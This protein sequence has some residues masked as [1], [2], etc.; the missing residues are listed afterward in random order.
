MS[1]VF[2][3]E[4]IQFM[5]DNAEARQYTELTD[6]LNQAFGK[7]YGMRQVK[8]A[9]NRMGVYNGICSLFSR[10]HMKGFTAG[11]KPSNLCHIGTE[12]P[13]PSGYLKVKISDN[14]HSWQYKHIVLWER[15]HGSVPQGHKVIFADG[16]NRNFAPDNLILVSNAE[17]MVM[18][19]KGLIYDDADLTKVGQKIAKVVVKIHEK[20][21]HK[22]TDEID[23]CG[24]NAGA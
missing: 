11:H 15:L 23:G 12:R 6:M 9:C 18:N 17:L 4:E 19:R 20:N 10:G 7:A 21:K 1:R 24:G 5:R 8:H 16:N 3:P 13:D 14:P 2:T 22:D